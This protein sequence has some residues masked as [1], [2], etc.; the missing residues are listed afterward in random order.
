MK[1]SE[2]APMEIAEELPSLGPVLDFMRLAWA[3]DHALHRVSRR[4][5]ATAGVTGP[6]RLLIRVVGRF[7]G[8]PQGRIAQLLHVHPSTVTGIV[9]RL[10]RQGFIEKRA[11][12]RDRRRTLLGLTPAGRRVNGSLEGTVEAAVLRTMQ[13][14]DEEDLAATRRVLESMVLNLEQEV[15]EAG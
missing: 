14:A 8:S 15:P 7:P 12:P 10:V 2:L 4:L 5:E 13:N 3:M 1:R 11:D 9:D 6:Q